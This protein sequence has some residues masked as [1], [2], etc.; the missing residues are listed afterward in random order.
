MR[1]V[2]RVCLCEH[3]IHMYV[4]WT[5]A[6]LHYT[7]DRLY[8]HSPFGA[9]ELKHPQQEREQRAEVVR[10]LSCQKTAGRPAAGQSKEMNLL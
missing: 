10:D 4:H 9:G 1:K 8:K 2:P 7:G 5:I 3:A 6:P